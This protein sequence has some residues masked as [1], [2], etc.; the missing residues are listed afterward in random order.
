MQSVIPQAAKSSSRIVSFQVK[1]TKSRARNLATAAPKLDLQ[2]SEA[3]ANDEQI[4]PANPPALSARLMQALRDDAD[5]IESLSDIRGLLVGPIT[6]VHEARIEELLSIMEE[7]DRGYQHMFREIHSRSDALVETTE[8]IKLDAAKTNEAIV[9]AST[10]Q[11]LNL[12][13]ASREMGHALKEMTQKFESNF[14]KLSSEFSHRIDTLASKTADDHQAFMNSITKRIDDHES[15]TFA[16]DEH[17]LVKL[18]NQI[19]TSE[20]NMKTQRSHDLNSLAEGLT[21]LSD[22]VTKLRMG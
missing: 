12:L 18:E 7:A 15:A 1:E 10:Q 8:V 11:D 6:R 4:L 13:Q 5:P 21:N 16:N 3:F 20:A 14:Q 19:A 2:S 17:I 22:V 9:N